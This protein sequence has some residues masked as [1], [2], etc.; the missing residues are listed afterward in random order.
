M[1]AWHAGTP[2]L[3]VLTL[4]PVH[5]VAGKYRYSIG[6]QSDAARFDDE[7]DALAKLRSTLPTTVDHLQSLLSKQVWLPPTAD[8]RLPTADCE[9]AVC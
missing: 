6:I 4:H 2:F 5:D 8:C 3:N 9:V 1:S 7:G